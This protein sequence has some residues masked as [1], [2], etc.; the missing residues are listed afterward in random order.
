[1]ALKSNNAAPEGES[2]VNQRLQKGGI[3][4]YILLF[5]LIGT[6]LYG[7]FLSFDKGQVLASTADLEKQTKD[8]Q[9]QIDTI[10]ANKVEVSQ[11]A[12][13]AL[14]TIESGETRWSEVITEVQKLL[15][16]DAQG[17]PQLN[18]VSYAGSADGKITLNMVTR[19]S[20]QPPF[21][22]V[23][24]IIAIFNSSVFFTEAYVPSIAKSSDESGQVTLS[25]LLNT[26]YQK[27]ETGSE[28]VQALPDSAAGIATNASAIKVPR[29]N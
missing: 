7:V 18:V 14:K 17:Q 11:N 27:P 19:P 1:M 2:Q 10:K 12:V 29:N 13:D 24:R 20:A 26:S 6:I 16:L 15:P 28:T 8:I 5:L 3:L 25:F 21:S 9:T 4:N 23:A 22:D